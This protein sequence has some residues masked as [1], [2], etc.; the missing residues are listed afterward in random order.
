MLSLVDYK[1]PTVFLNTTTE[2]NN[3]G[4]CG[5]FFF[6]DFMAFGRSHWVV[7]SCCVLQRICVKMAEED[8]ISAMVRDLERHEGPVDGD[9]A[10]D[11]V[12]G[13]CRKDILNDLRGRRVS[14]VRMT[15]WSAEMS[16]YT[17]FQ[18]RKHGA[19]RYQCHYCM[20]MGICCNA[21]QFLMRDSAV[22]AYV[23]GVQLMG[24]EQYE[25]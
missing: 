8:W 9:G 16:T 3:R 19:A 14:G 17:V 21:H 22:E 1:Q 25:G 12:R 15:P 20:V 5:K 2:S 6:D 23:T 13:L 10:A 7:R 4:W 24:Y 18:K 11:E